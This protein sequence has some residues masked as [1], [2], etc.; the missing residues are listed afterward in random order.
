M[1]KLTLA[2]GRLRGSPDD[3]AGSAGIIEMAP[4]LHR[5]SLGS[6][7]AAITG[8]PRGPEPERPL[9]PTLA[10]S[11]GQIRALSEADQGGV[12]LRLA[13]HR[14]TFPSICKP[15]EEEIGGIVE[16][17]AAATWAAWIAGTHEP[18]WNALP[19]R[20]REKIRAA[21]KAGLVAVGLL[22]TTGETGP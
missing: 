18:A 14:D 10:D 21:S 5:L 16:R 19:E 3:D 1:R 22:P 7:G 9:A 11:G 8:R 2:L 6:V 15:D 12:V 20:V 4:D 13:D 17:H